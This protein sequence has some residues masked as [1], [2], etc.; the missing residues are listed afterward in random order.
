M[1]S[2]ITVSRHRRIET[3]IKLIFFAAFSAGLVYASRASITVPRS[4]GFYRFFAWESI[5]A[6]II[7]NIGRWFQDPFSVH[8]FVS[9]ILLAA[10]LLPGLPGI[11]FLRTRGIPDPRR[12]EDGSLVGIEKT[13][14]LVT[15]GPFKYIRHPLYSS[16]LLLAWGVFF[17]YPSVVGAGLALG[18]TAF[19][20]AAAKVEE[21]ENLSYFG[22]DYRTYMRTTKMFI[23]FVF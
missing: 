14:R 1:G 19:L 17:K 4:H 9:W 22:S 20:L 7:L 18:A 5:L 23:P 15:T 11:H 8:Q 10:S 2:L 16:L 12:R 13:T 3:V 6:L 21:A